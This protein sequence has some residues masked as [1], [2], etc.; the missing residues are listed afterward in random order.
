MTPE[1]YAILKEKLDKLISETGIEDILDHRNK[2]L[3]KDQS[4]RFRWDLFNS[5]ES[6]DIPIFY[7][8]KDN[9][10]DTALKKYIKDHPVLGKDSN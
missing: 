3:G 2:R 8:Y 1:H 9:H 10:I 4:M 6:F 5:S 7:D